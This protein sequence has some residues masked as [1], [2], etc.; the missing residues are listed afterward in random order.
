MILAPLLKCINERHYMYGFKGGEMWY[1][2]YQNVIDVIG[3]VAETREG[4]KE[5]RLEGD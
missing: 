3:L 2:C 4:W 5:G 1:R